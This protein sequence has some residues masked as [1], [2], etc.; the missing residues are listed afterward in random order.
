[1]F[2]NTTFMGMAIFQDATVYPLPRIYKQIRFF[3][4]TII[5]NVWIRSE[6]LT[7]E[8][9]SKITV[10]MIPQWNSSTVALSRF[11]NSLNAGNIEEG[12]IISWIVERKEK[13]QTIYNKLAEV[14]AS[15]KSYVS[16]T[17]QSN[18]EYDHKVTPVFSDKIGRELLSDRV[19]A[20]YN[21]YYLIDPYD[22]KTFMFYLNVEGGDLNNNTN[23][24]FQDNF[25]EYQTVTT[26][27]QDYMTG[28]ISAIITKE[29]LIDGIDQGV[30]YIHEFR[31][32]VNN[33]RP[34]LFKT[35]KGEIFKVWTS[36]L[37]L[38]VLENGIESQPMVV[39]IDF[40]EIGKV[41]D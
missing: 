16:Y 37:K 40:R 36:N 22:G 17:T 7:D 28:S 34:K 13:S 26:G 29:I 18:K 39:T 5:N 9:V 4:D 8:E 24:S 14:D 3:S 2:F 32:F 1:M 12:T 10:D 41:V 35:R 25:T 33:K 6:V 19:L 11:N 27:T 38:S 30:D 15:E 31:Q 23:D 20:D 21:D